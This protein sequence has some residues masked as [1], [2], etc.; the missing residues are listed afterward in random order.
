[1]RT[2]VLS[3]LLLSSLNALALDDKYKP[4]ASKDP[5][6]NDQTRAA[7]AE[8]E[9]RKAEAARNQDQPLVK[10]PLGGN[11]SIQTGSVGN[12]PGVVV[13]KEIK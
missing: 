7:A 2:F 13:K 1:M 10:V 4:A 8:M 12:S 11:T 3:I 6:Y 9:R 5:I